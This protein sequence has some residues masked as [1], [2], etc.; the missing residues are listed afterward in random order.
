MMRLAE[1]YLSLTERTHDLAILDAADMETEDTRRLLL[2]GTGSSVDPTTAT[3]PDALAEWERRRAIPFDVEIGVTTGVYV[4]LRQAADR[5]YD[6]LNE[7]TRG[8]TVLDPAFI[9][10]HPQYLPFLQHV[11]GS[12]SK[13]QLKRQVGSVS[14]TSISRPAGE[15]LAAYLTARVDPASIRKGE[16]LRRLD[17]TLEGIVRDL[18]G[19]LL[20]ESVVASALE[21]ER[22]PFVR[23][24]DYAG[25]TGVVY[26]FRADFV[27][28]NAETPKVFVE[29]RKSSTRHASLY[30]KDKMFSAINWKG[31]R[32]DLL[33]V[34]VVEGPWTGAT[35]QI[36]AKVFDYVVPLGRS[37]E[38]AQTIAA[39]L[40]GDTSKLRWLIDFRISENRG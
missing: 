6:A 22:L 12:F 39:Y 7:A 36:M 4:H 29:V 31:H 19:R 5:I 26:D 9:S 21:R 1:L 23:E 32:R 2:A 24:K 14:D 35:L 16:I 25:L 28:P 18:V 15:R 30:A 20:L 17:S 11:G 34:L 40:A 37:A 13:A 27:L 3:A 8:F 38:L 10:A 33:G